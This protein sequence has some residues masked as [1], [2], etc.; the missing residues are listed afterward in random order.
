MFNRFKHTNSRPEEVRG[1]EH[2]RS[3]PTAGEGRRGRSFPGRLLA[4]VVGLVA[5]LALAGCTSGTYPVDIFY[6][7]H[8]QQ[9]YKS[10]EPPRLSGVAG[11]VAFYPA[12]PNTTDGS[13][14]HLYEINCQMCHGTDGRESGE[15]LRRLTLS[16]AEGGY[17]YEYNILDPDT[18]EPRPP[19]LTNLTAAEISGYLANP[20]PARPFGPDSVMPPFGKL[21]SESERNAIIAYIDTLP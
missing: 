18:L 21:L 3:A 6:E 13:G 17:G 2:N 15:V 12:P 7:Q 9:S 4:V 20:G 5:A 16:P 10:H 19:D 14:A 8:Y 11:A 1:H